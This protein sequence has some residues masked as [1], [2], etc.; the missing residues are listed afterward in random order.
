MKGQP[1]SW[2][3][4]AIGLPFGAE[5]T[6]HFPFLVEHDAQV[7]DDQNKHGIGVVPRIARAQSTPAS[8]SRH[9]HA[10]DSG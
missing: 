3:F 1:P 2:H 8:A 5:K 7:E 4:T 6:F 9:P 10:L